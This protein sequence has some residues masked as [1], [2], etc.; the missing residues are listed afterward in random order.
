MAQGSSHPRRDCKRTCSQ[1]PPVVVGRIRFFAGCWTAGLGC[2]LA[3]GGRPSSVL[4]LFLFLVLFLLPRELLRSLEWGQVKGTSEGAGT[5][6]SPHLQTSELPSRPSRS[7]LGGSRS[8]G[9]AQG[10]ERLWKGTK[11]RKGVRPWEPF[12]QLPATGCAASA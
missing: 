3:L 8:P 10:R 4:L 12:Q 7:L 6:R 5:S 9:A 2:R 1:V 11:I